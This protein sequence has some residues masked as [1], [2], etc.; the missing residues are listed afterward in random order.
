MQDGVTDFISL[1]KGPMRFLK[2]NEF[3][4]TPITLIL[5]AKSYHSLI[6]IVLISSKEAGKEREIERSYT[7]LDPEDLC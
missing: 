7:K 4:S 2:A 1:I 5:G 3:D 6:L